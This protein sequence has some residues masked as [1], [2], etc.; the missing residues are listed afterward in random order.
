MLIELS[1]LPPSVQTFIQQGEPLE[2]TKNGQIIQKFIVTPNKKELPF[3][4]DLKAMQHA[5]DA[6]RHEVPK[7]A[8]MDLDSFDKWLRV[9]TQ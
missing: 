6:P 8:L 2:F 4:Y 5:V 9:I 7:E 3:N 1:T